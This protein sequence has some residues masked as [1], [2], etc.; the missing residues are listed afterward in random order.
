[1][2]HLRHEAKG[3]LIDAD[4]LLK[5][6]QQDFGMICMA[7]FF[8]EGQMLV[9]DCTTRADSIADAIYSLSFCFLELVS[10]SY[11]NW[12]Y[13]FLPGNFIWEIER[14]RLVIYI[15]QWCCVSAPR[16][17]SKFRNSWGF[18]VSVETVRLRPGLGAASSRHV[19]F[20]VDFLSGWNIIFIS[21]HSEW[22][23]FKITA[24]QG[25]F[26]TFCRPD[27][28]TRQVFISSH[29]SSIS[30]SQKV[31]FFLGN[32]PCFTLL[33]PSTVNCLACVIHSLRFTWNSIS[34]VDFLHS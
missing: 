32:F 15:T 28:V 20:L 13:T 9:S 27:W 30:L 29:L 19:S 4:D 18:W 25:I 12:I 26:I 34:S 6:K 8:L 24:H 11:T 7:L 16:V 21:V 10:L 17:P 33:W 14:G 31:H 23:F 3:G 2:E 1:M 5:G 22:Q